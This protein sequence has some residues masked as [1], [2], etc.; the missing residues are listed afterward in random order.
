MM[1]HKQ[2]G[3]YAAPRCAVRALQI[4]ESFLESGGEEDREGRPGEPIQPGDIFVF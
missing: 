4:E 1:I 2:Q 3:G